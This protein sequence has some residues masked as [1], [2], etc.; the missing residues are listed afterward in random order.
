MANVGMV[1]LLLLSDQGPLTVRVKLCLFA[2]GI[3][4]LVVGLFALEANLRRACFRF[5]MVL[6]LNVIAWAAAAAS[7]VLTSVLFATQLVCCS[8]GWDFPLLTDFVRQGKTLPVRRASIC[9]S[10][11][12]R[13]GMRAAP[14]YA[15]M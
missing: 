1:P 13:P 4:Q 12:A 3:L 15:A 11:P 2:P 9:R 10:R 5:Y 7:A 8:P 14:R 6:L